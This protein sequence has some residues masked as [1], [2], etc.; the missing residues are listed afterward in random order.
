LEHLWKD[1]G[2][3]SRDKTNRDKARW[4]RD[5]DSVAGVLIVGAWAGRE[6]G[7]NDCSVV[8]GALDKP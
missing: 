2:K 8:N 3:V 4:C 1:K 5:I 7:G 6:G